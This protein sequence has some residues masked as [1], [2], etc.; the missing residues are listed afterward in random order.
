MWLYCIIVSEAIVSV[1]FD[2]FIIWL[3]C[4]RAKPSLSNIRLY[5]IIQLLF[6]T[7]KSLSYTMD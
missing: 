7:G 4:K 2:I 5:F 6:A 3:L 1:L